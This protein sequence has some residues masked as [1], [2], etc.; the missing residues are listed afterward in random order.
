M[1]LLCIKRQRFVWLQFFSDN[2]RRT[3]GQKGWQTDSGSFSMCP[4]SGA[5]AA[6]VYSVPISVFAIHFALVF[7]VADLAYPCLLHTCCFSFGVRVCVCIR[8]CALSFC[9]FGRCFPPKWKKPVQHLGRVQMRPRRTKEKGTHTP[10]RSLIVAEQ[11][12]HTHSTLD[13]RL[14]KYKTKWARAQYKRVLLL[15]TSKEPKMFSTQIA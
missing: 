1:C 6:F 3:F 5:T 4:F 10:R 7:T 8:F 13:T 2:F 11:H 12:T 14:A 9:R 15:P